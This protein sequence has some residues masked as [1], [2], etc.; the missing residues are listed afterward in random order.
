MQH[1][2]RQIDILTIGCIETLQH[3]NIAYQETIATKI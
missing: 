3:I 2:K 1:F